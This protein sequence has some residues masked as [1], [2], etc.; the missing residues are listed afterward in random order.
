MKKLNKLTINPSKMM[1]NEELV[2]L[3]GG[4]GYY[5]PPSGYNYCY[6]NGVIVGTIY[7]GEC[8]GGSD[9]TSGLSECKNLYGSSTNMSI[10]N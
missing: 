5:N 7:A 8:G 2:N 3:R 9:G 6:N 4:Y 10:C 1:G